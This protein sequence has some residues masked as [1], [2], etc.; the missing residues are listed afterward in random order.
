MTNVGKY[1]FYAAK[2][3]GQNDII[4]LSSINMASVTI[5]RLSE[6]F[7][8][9]VGLMGLCDEMFFKSFNFCSFEAS[10]SFPE[11]IGNQTYEQGVFCIPFNTNSCRNLSFSTLNDVQI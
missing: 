11:Q 5:T 4:M 10:I 3:C 9:Y 8:K 2:K 7:F 6:R 1:G